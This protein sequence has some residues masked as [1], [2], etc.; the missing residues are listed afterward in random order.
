L[1]YLVVKTLLGYIKVQK[2]KQVQV[3]NKCTISKIRY[4]YIHYTTLR[5]Q[6]DSF[7]FLWS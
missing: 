4:G 2:F 7:Q 6:P 3:Y 1:E 5:G